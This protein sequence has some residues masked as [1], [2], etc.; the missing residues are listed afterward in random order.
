MILFSD[1]PP[2]L[3][4]SQSRDEL[5]VKLRRGMGSNYYYKTV[6]II[7]KHKNYVITSTLIWWCLPTISWPAAPC[8]GARLTGNSAEH[9]PGN[10]MSSKHVFNYAVNTFGFVQTFFTFPWSWGIKGHAVITCNWPGNFINCCLHVDGIFTQLS[11]TV[12]GW[13]SVLNFGLISELTT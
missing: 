5:W 7:T 8:S 10:P 1:H 13:V 11:R 6:N 4:F 3:S 9:C 2:H 12:L